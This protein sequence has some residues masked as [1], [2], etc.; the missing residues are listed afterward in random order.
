[1]TRFQAAIEVM[2]AGIGIILH[3]CW[4]DP[5]LACFL[6][7]LKNCSG[8]VT[9]ADVESAGCIYFTLNIPI[10]IGSLGFDG[11]S[12][13]RGFIYHCHLAFG[14]N[15]TFIARASLLFRVSLLSNR[16]KFDCL[17]LPLGRPNSCLVP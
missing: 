11:R 10:E 3:E 9:P 7:F 2:F 13:S 16:L 6:T 12:V 14:I 5:S 8:V 17:N 15:S 4:N 1:M